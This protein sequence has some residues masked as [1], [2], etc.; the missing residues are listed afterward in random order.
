ML[1]S[2]LDLGDVE[3][4]AIMTHRKN[5]V[6]VNADLPPEELIRQVLAAPYT[7]IP[8]WRGTSDNIVG[9]LHVKKL[10]NAVKAADGELDQIDAAALANEPWFIPDA[11][12]LLSQLQSFR[13]RHEHFAIVVDEYGELLGIVTLEDIL[14]EIVGEIEDEHDTE[15]EGV[16]PLKDGAIVVEGTVTIRDLNRQ[17]EWRLPDEDAS[18]IAG[19]VLHEAQRIPDLG[20][21]F[22]F[23][24]FRFE[25][26]GRQRNQITSIKITPPE[27]AVPDADDAATETLGESG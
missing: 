2:V 23:H 21:V 1:R 15:I 16:K 8:L 26:L 3:V 17:F 12:D 6:T 18:T 11:T 9:V 25:I 20:Q 5:I 7:R 4:G 13:R 24:D 19:L 10:F 27:T 22:M 14:E